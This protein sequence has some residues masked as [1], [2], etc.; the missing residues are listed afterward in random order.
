MYCRTRKLK[1]EKTEASWKSLSV[2]PPSRA[3]SA[4]RRFCSRLRSVVGGGDDLLAT[5]DGILDVVAERDEADGLRGG[6]G[7]SSAMRSGRRRARLTRQTP[8]PM[9]GVTPRKRPLIPFSVDSAR[10][11]QSVS[12]KQG[13]RLRR[14]RRAGGEVKGA[15]V[16]ELQD[17]PERK[18]HPCRC[19]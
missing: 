2:P 19:T 4:E 10:I 16:R 11:R 5:V 14:R 13:G 1:T 17:D 7:I 9:R 3:F 6:E 18:T 12:E 15:G 8:R